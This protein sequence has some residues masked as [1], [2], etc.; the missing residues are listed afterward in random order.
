MR[1]V[2]TSGYQKLLECPFCGGEAKVNKWEGGFK[3][4]CQKVFCAVLGPFNTEAE[5]IEAWNTR[6][7]KAVYEDGN[8]CRIVTDTDTYKPE[9]TCKPVET[10]GIMRCPDCDYPLGIMSVPAYC[11]GCG[12]KVVE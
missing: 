3:V 11:A 10:D 12:A 5:A 7:N 1:S 8:L 2:S 4:L 9:R 6:T